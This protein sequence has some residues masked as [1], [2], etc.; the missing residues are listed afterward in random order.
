MWSGR[1]GGGCSSS[2]TSSVR[3]ASTGSDGLEN[4]GGLCGRGDTGFVIAPEPGNP[5]DRAGGIAHEG[6]L[7][8]PLAELEIREEVGHFAPAG[9]A[10]AQAL[11]APRGPDGAASDRGQVERLLSRRLR[12]QERLQ[13]SVLRIRDA[14]YDYVSPNRHSPGAAEQ[15][16]FSAA[17]AG[18]GISARILDAGGPAAAQSCTP[19]RTA[20]TAAR[21]PRGRRRGG[22][23]RRARRV[24][25]GVDRR[26]QSCH[27]RRIEPPGTRHR[28]CAAS[29]SP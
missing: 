12:A 6:M 1:S 25:E 27:R 8:G 16:G 20:R 13:E 24:R 18:D 11:A 17:A 28:D 29:A 22:G 26:E 23:P 10:R 14:R 2:P 7:R 19:A 5:Q 9:G 21:A 4:E 3:E 15:H